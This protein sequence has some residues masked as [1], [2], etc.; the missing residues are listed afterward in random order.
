MRTA[1]KGLTLIELIVVVAII[2][3]L[4]AI[5]YPSY[6]DQVM[7]SRRSAAKGALLELSQIMERNYTE[8]NRYDQDS[9]GVVFDVDDNTDENSAD[10]LPFKVSP[11][12]GT[13]Y[14][15][16]SVEVSGTSSY[17]LYAEPEADTSQ[18]DDS[19]GTLEL[20]SDG[21]RSPANCW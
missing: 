14:Y 11:R 7:K 16:L 18:D 8:T 19:C 4:A 3:I 13:A 1:Q 2:A 10:N 5:A 6:Q 15:N 17:I 21:V 20:G 12:N 9:G